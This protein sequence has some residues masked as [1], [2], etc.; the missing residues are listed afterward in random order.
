[1]KF[2]QKDKPMMF[3]QTAIPDLFFTE[4]LSQ[5]PGDYVKAYI[6]ILFLSK[7]NKDVKIND[8]SRM[9]GIP[10]KTI[11][12]G[13]KYLEENG[14]ITKK[15]TGGYVMVDIQEEILNKLY[16]PNITLTPDKIN[17]NSQN[18]ERVKAI[19]HINN[20]YFQGTM[21]PIWYSQIDLW[22]NKYNFEEQVMI[23]L[24]DYCRNRNALHKN[25]VQT[26]AEAWGNNK[27]RTW[28]ELERYYQKQDK[29]NQ[30]KKTIAKRLGKQN[31]LTQYEEAYIEKWVGEYG[32]GLDIIEIALKRTTFKSNPTFEY[33]NN[34]ITD[35]HER[36]LK[37]PEE[38]EKFLEQRKKQSKDVKQMQQKTSKASQRE[39]SN[40]DFLYS[41]KE[42][43]G[44]N[45]G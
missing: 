1:M 23:A 31:N 33:F 34:I 16:K 4:Y 10:Y 2:E 3:S 26:V 29:L 9:L 37:T 36:N 8:L 45:D 21:G 18:K 5:I 19:E 32:Y 38:I 44:E 39:Y 17:Q 14:L 6:Y 15:G 41:N 30:I 20:E 40:L 11:G 27:V 43:E 25:Y 42:V 24:F 13:L 12:E 35:W 28:S 22:F 7:Y